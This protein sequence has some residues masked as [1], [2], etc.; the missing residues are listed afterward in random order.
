MRTAA[1][2]PGEGRG[3]GMK[4]GKDTTG[5]LFPDAPSPS[6][7]PTLP[8]P[9]S[10]RAAILEALRCGERLT[11]RDALARGWGWRLAADVFALAHDHGWPIA[12]HLIPNPG[13]N[14]IA[15]Y[16]LPADTRQMGV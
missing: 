4:P 7:G 8:D 12:A 9:T 16:W 14:Q 5:D 13:G 3:R 2:D 6:P 10:R 15:E 1:K 11:H